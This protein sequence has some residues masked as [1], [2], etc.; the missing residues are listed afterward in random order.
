MLRALSRRLVPI[1]RISGSFRSLSRAFANRNVRRL[2]MAWAL[3]WV[4]DWS[5]LVALSIFAFRSGGSLA[6][7]L[8]GLIRMLP[9][10]AVAPFAASLGDRYRRDRVLLSVEVAWAAALV[11]SA[12]AFYLDAPVWIVYVLAAVTG[13]CM[14][15]FRPTQAALLPWL[16]RTPEEL[17]AA[18]AASGLIEGLGTLIGPLVGGILATAADPG[19]V[20]AAAAVATVLGGIALATLGTEGEELRRRKLE[21]MGLL[22]HAAAG[23]AALRAHRDARFLVSLFAAQAFVR[24][25][26]NVLIVVAAL[27]VLDMGTSGVGV[28]SAAV[29]AGG[30]L[31]SIVAVSLTGRRLAMPVGV[32]LALWGLP[33]GAIALVPRAGAS[34]AMLAVVGL[35]NAILDVAGFSLM[36]RIVPDQVLA[37]IFGLMF[38]LVMAAV[39]LGSI[40]LPLLIDLAGI[41]WALVVTGLILP[42]LTVLSW[43]RLARMDRAAAP[44]AERLAVFRDVP[45]F[46]GLSVAATEYLAGCLV[47]L[48]VPAG[49]RLITEGERGDRFYIVDQGEFEVTVGGRPVARQGPGGYFG[50]IALLRDVPRM[51]TVTSL[52]DGVVHAIDGG[53]F[54][55]AVTG[56]AHSADAADRVI[57]ARLSETGTTS[58]VPDDDAGR[59]PEPAG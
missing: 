40:V 3:A 37:R 57:T 12:T 18:N 13:I 34:V 32:G 39:G 49:H 29:G 9:S 53:D 43:Q 14:T 25:A 48:E 19:L 4:T 41:R 38:G 28:L 54:L 52:A 46:D 44:S 24:G 42:L 21:P 50:E 20:F 27:G 17:I 22:R 7:G 58:S 6:V 30:L 59:E 55:A 2:Q 5:Y 35:G 51:A 1:D 26:L 47:R 8:V 11:G 31:G 33:I 23:I 45:I 56:H 16:A 10:A 15:I 36:Q